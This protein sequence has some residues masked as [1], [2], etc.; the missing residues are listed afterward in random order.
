MLFVNNIYVTVKTVNWSDPSVT[1]IF[2]NEDTSKVGFH[3][4][5]K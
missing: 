2:V 3:K 4:L 5:F 1:N